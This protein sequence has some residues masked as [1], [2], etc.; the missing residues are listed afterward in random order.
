[1]LPIPSPRQSLRYE[2]R[3]LQVSWHRSLE[4]VPRDAP[5]I[6]IAHEFFDALPVHQFQKTERGWC[7]RLVD[8][9]G[10]RSSPSPHT[11]PAT[12]SCFQL[13]IAGNLSAE[14]TDSGL[15]HKISFSTLR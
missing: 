10:L 8:T 5:A 7:E 15:G 1:M 9:A 13:G 3:G 12:A 4:D 6:F 11:P 14:E 2:S